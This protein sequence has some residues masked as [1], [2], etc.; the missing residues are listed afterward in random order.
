MYLR[1]IEGLP[2]NVSAQSY[3]DLPDGH[4]DETAQARLNRLKSQL[5][6]RLPE[7]HIHQYHATWRGTGPE[8]DLDRFCE[9]VKADLTR[10]IDQELEAFRSDAPWLREHREHDEFAEQRAAHFI[11]RDDV[12]R[13][14]EQYLGDA[15][16]GPLILHGVAG[17][18][19]TAV[20]AH[21]YL[22]HSGDAS[23]PPNAPPE[24]NQGRVVIA[25]FL[26]TTPSS[27]D[28]RSLLVSLCSELGARF[29][30]DAGLPAE[31]SSLARELEERLGW[32]TPD[33]PIL[34]FLDALDQLD[35]TDGAH[36][37]WW[38][39]RELPEH[40]KLV[41]SVLEQEGDAGAAFRSAEHLFVD[42]LVKLGPFSPPRR[43]GV[44]GCLAYGGGADAPG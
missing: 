13:A 2:N 39:P 11:G 29:G 22:R 35:P 41:A 27:S 7:A 36:T 20:V 23:L 6:A 25:R 28:L 32:A 9:D 12:L 40:V 30:N 3:C 26:G 38:L 31:V 37:L 19:K 8:W 18:G 5:R 24:L 44:A 21:T 4:R 1:E 42:R 33:R 10:I 15:T 34:V 16:R 43:R 14:V 17:S